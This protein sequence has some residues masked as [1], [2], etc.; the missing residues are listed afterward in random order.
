[1]KKGAVHEAIRKLKV[2][3][4][5]QIG[6]EVDNATC[7]CESPLK[8]SESTT[9]SCFQKSKMTLS[10][11]Q[12][13]VFERRVLRLGEHGVG[14]LFQ[15]LRGHVFLMRRKHPGVTERIFKLATPVP[16][17]LILE[18]LQDFRASGHSALDDRINVFKIN[19]HRGG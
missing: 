13:D 14:A 7:D 9:G 8:G 12:G 5:V 4:P 6:G 10:R 19:H 11:A 15:F 16:I 2:E 18:G 3:H 1:M 17:E